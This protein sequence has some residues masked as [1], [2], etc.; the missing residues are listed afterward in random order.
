MKI[1]R[2]FASDMRQA[3]RQV[4]EALGADAVILS[5]KNVQG[6]IELVA[7]VDYDE[8]AFDTT[9]PT[10]IES[11]PRTLTDDSASL[12]S[13]A[14]SANLNNTVFDQSEKPKQD[15]RDSKPA[16]RQEQPRVEWSQDPVLKEMRREMQALRRMMENELSELTW[17]D[18][19]HRRPQTQDLI[20]RLMALGLDAGHCKELAYRVED[21]E[22]PEQAWRQALTQLGAEIPAV[23]QDL[24]DEG[25]ILA[26]VGPTGVGKTTTIAKLA[27]RFCLRHGNR[28]LALISADSY[29]IGAQEQLQNYGRILDVPVRS[30]TTPEELNNALHAFADKRMVLIDTAGMGQRDLQLT[31]RLALL[32]KGN[33][34]VKSLLT[35]SATT[36]R[37]ALSH[38]IRAFDIVSPI[39]VV[40]TKMDEAA[41]LGGVLSA[42]LEAKLPLAFVTDGQR[43]PEDIHNA[44]ADR[45]MKH[46]VELSEL[47]GGSPDEEYLAMAFGGM[48]EHAH[49]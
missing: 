43:V 39:G 23:E 6:G 48:N 41:S 16:Q 9:Q 12:S 36:Q 46:A 32:S 49:V 21:A 8:S 45:L 33:H 27:A 20:R 44:Y 40:L 29:R 14:R 31:E 1:R 30:V 37:S 3:L 7:A 28:H 34:P 15:Y 11:D 19:G 17:R 2:F 10:S 25:G 13:A 18:L 22:T 24:L 4:R 47:M 38:A 42:V 5:N 26:L 35:L